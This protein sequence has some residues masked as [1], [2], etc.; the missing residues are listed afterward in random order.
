LQVYLP[1]HCPLYAVVAHSLLQLPMQL[2]K[3]AK[4]VP[5]ASSALTLACK[6]AS[7][8]PSWT[9][10]LPATVTSGGVVSTMC[11]GRERGAAA[12]PLRSAQV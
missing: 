4:P 5:G 6:S 9:T 3:H 11:T 1:P 10:V 2:S 8:V 12:S 7:A